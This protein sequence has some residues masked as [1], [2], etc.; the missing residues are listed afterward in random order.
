MDL[1]TVTSLRPARARADLVLAPGESVMGGGSW[2]F[3]EPQL[4]VSG[5]VDL[6]DLG[7]PPITVTPD[8]LEIAATCTIAELRAMEAQPTWHAHPLFA[9]CCS[10]LLGSFKV[11]NVATVGGNI[12]L[13][14]PAGPM[15]SMASALDAVAVIWT[16]D[17]S[18]REVPVAH[19]VL[20][21]RT[22]GLA[23]GEVVRSIRVPQASLEATTAFR[24]IALSPL[25][26]SAALVIARRN[27]DGSVVLTVT[28]STTHPVQWRFAALPS[29][30]EVTAAIETHTHWYDD[31][32]G[33]PDWRASITAELARQVVAEL[34]V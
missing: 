16:P 32:H 17:G 12:C 3:S 22:T 1:T 26:R 10:A 11:W 9:Q 8:G 24:Q 2:L 5:L 13:A 20:D 30:D 7:W 4:E 33:A 31:A 14:L 21:V 29:A 19:L 34:A 28:A 23:P 6:M 18:E 25:G 27:V 15:T